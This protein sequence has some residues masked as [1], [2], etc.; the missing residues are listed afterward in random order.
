[1]GCISPNERAQVIPGFDR[2]ALSC[3]AQSGCLE[4]RLPDQASACM[5]PVRAA[6]L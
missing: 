3:I 2:Q 4:R 1:M 5:H 6:R